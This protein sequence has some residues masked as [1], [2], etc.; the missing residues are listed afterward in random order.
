MLTKQRKQEI[1]KNLIDKLTRQKAVVFADYTGL[2]V[3]QIQDLRNRLKKEGIEFQVAKKTLID[4]ALE[5]A[6][7]K[8]IKTKDI[9][10]Q[11]AVAFGYQDEVS[12]AKII[13][14]FSKEND[15][16]KVLAGVIQGEFFET[17]KIKEL[18]KLPSR[19]ELLAKL[20]GNIA[21]PMS[22]LVNALESNLRNFV[23]LLS[24]LNH[25]A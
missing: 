12:P 19:Q 13:Y 1:I 23:Y 6:G 22:G 4:L 14:N 11:I 9:Q 10:G 18:A 5:K 8:N 15:A 20:V 17:D 2:K 21:A 3:K 24:K 16:L 7:L 25:E